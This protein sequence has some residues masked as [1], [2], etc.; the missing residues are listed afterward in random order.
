MSDAPIDLSIYTLSSQENI[1]VEDP[2]SFVAE[3]L[4]HLSASLE[5]NDEYLVFE[6]GVGKI[7][8]E[9]TFV[10]AE[11]HAN[12]QD[13]LDHIQRVLSQMAYKSPTYDQNS[14]VST[15]EELEP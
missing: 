15:D 11:A 9:E 1:S 13:D 14:T 8:A 4:A 12:T 2:A 5:S 3:T 6:V 10:L 7:S